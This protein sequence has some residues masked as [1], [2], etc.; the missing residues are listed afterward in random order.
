MREVEEPSIGPR[1]E[2]L[3]EPLLAG[4]ATSPSRV[5]DELVA[6]I[7]KT[8]ET[9]KVQ[10]AR[11]R[12]GRLVRKRSSILCRGSRRRGEYRD[13]YNQ[14]LRRVTRS[15]LFSDIQELLSPQSLGI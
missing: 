15:I 1:F 13:L 14:Q 2:V 4:V 7:R 5:P 9:A 3:I 6:K 12:S 11:L 10:M 8:A